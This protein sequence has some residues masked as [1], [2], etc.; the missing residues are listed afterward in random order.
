M[1][2]ELFASDTWGRFTWQQNDGDDEVCH[3]GHHY[4]HLNIHKSQYILW[5]LV[6]TRD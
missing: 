5:R 3:K 1:G 6:Q 4:L 2:V